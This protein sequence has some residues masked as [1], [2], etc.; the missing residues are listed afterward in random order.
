[1]ETTAILTDREGSVVDARFRLLHWLGG[2]SESSV[3]STQTDGEGARPAAIKL[4][5][6]AVPGAD[7][8]LAGW[9]AAARID[10]P[11]LLRVF[12]TGRSRLDGGPA[13]GE[14]IYAVTELADEVLAE[15]LPDRPLTPD[16][17]RE[18]LGPVLD[19]LALLHSRG[20][21][22]GRIKPTN[23]LVVADSLKLSAECS[24][25][26]S[27]KPTGAAPATSIFDAPE[28]SRGLIS[29]AA[30]V[31]S[32]GM[33]MVAALTQRTPAWDRGSGFEPD[34]R[35]ALQEPFAGIVRDC[36]R[37]DPASRPTLDEIKAGLAGETATRPEG[38]VLEEPPP[39]SSRWAPVWLAGAVF[40]GIGVTALILHGRQ[41]PTS[42]PTAV[43]ESAPAAPQPDVS[44][45]PAPAQAAPQA[46][47]HPA[48][49]SPP[50]KPSPAPS[51]RPAPAQSATLQPAAPSPAAAAPLPSD[52]AILKRVLPDVLPSAQASIRGKIRIRVRVQV[53]PSGAV[54]DAVSDSPR[55]SPYFNRIALQAAQAWQFAPATAGS[56]WELQFEFRR[57]GPSVT[58]NAR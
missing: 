13:D 32:L 36:L 55:A 43:E 42:A 18:M 1:M 37:L 11:H 12:S 31:W 35:P 6:A 44:Q 24:P 25:L 8:R 29:P 7:T 33:T 45:T 54:T 23:I 19:A 9:A 15:I 50:L 3:Y 53:D 51:T 10:H 46:P 49:V 22:H 38:L 52:G 16:E 41:S 20:Y 27:G 48:R 30:D 26:A 57:D 58:A 56:V 5:P 17:T 39:H 34:V 47:A 40:L 28:L 14:V 21:V 2:T 4:A